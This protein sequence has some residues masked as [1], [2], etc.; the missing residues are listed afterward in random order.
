MAAIDHDVGA[1]SRG[2]ELR[3]AAGDIFSIIVRLAVAATQYDVPVFVTRGF[4]R[5][6]MS[7]G[8]DAEEAVRVADRFQCIDGDAEAAVG[9]VLEADGAGQSAGR[10]GAGP[11]FELILGK[12]GTSGS[13]G[14]KV[15]Y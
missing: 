14:I 4:H 15:V 7:A 2:T 11:C 6:N 1:D 9:A 10:T 5:G 12:T 8:I 13:P 3:L